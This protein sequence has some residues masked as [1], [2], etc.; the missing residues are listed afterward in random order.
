[1]PRY[2]QA[3][4]YIL[5]LT[6]LQL[7]FR[8]S[9]SY[10]PKTWPGYVPGY[11]GMVG[12][13]ARIGARV[14]PEYSIPYIKHPSNVSSLPPTLKRRDIPGYVDRIWVGTRVRP[15]YSVPYYLA[16]FTPHLPLVNAENG[17]PKLCPAGGHHASAILP[18]ERQALGARRVLD[19]HAQQPHGDVAQD[20]AKH[21]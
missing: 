21:G 19:G 16:A 5:L 13:H 9:H 12:A 3:I 17:H 4:N 18:H 14:P 6:P 15:E 20:G 11:L 8:T 1:M 2:A 10:T 7:I